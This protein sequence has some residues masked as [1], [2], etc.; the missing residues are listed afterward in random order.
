[1]IQIKPMKKL[2]L[3]LSLFVAVTLSAQNKAGDIIG[4]YMNPDADA[5]LKIY[6]TSGKYFGKLI[7]TKNAG[8]LDDQNPD[9]S[10]RSQKRLGLVIMNNFKFDGDDT[11]EGGTIYDPKN[12]KT[13]DCK[14]T[15]DAKGNLDIRGYIGISLL[16][17]TSH[18]TKIEFKEP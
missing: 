16:G 7:W 17:R 6:E 11:W 5:V 10:K 14:V 2:I 8:K 9:V 1:M 13:Y 18:F 3:F 15:R 4:T 12:G